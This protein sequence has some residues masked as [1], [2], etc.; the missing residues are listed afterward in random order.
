MIRYRIQPIS[1]ELHRFRVRLL[2]DD[3]DGALRITLPAWIP[4]SYMI[5]DFARNILDLEAYCNALPVTLEK[6]D[7]QTW[8]VGPCR[9]M[10]SL[11]YDV[12]AWD[13]SVRGAHLDT[14][15]AYFNGTS[16]FLRVIDRDREACEVEILPPEGE[17]FEHWR[18]ATTLVRKGAGPFGFGLYQAEDYWE[19]IDNPVE[20][21]DFTLGTFRVSGIEHHLAITG[22][23]RGD[24][25]RIC[26]D[27]E[28][29]CSTHVEMFGE[30]P[31]LEQYLFQLTVVG[32]GYGGLEHRRCTSLLA[33]RDDLPA[34]GRK[35]V[36]DGYRRLLGLCSHE[37]FHLWNVKRITPEV[38]Q[39]ADLASEVHTPLLWAFEG[40]TSYYDDLC[41]VRSGCIGIDGYLELLAQSIT[42]VQRIP[43][44]FRQSIAESSFDAWTKLYKQDENAPNAIVSYYAKGALVALALD[45]TIRVNTEGERS[46]DDVMRL[47][48]QRHGRTGKGVRNGDIEAIVSEVSGEEMGAFFDSYVEGTEDPP[49]QRLLRAVGIGMALRPARGRS[50]QGGVRRDAEPAADGPPPLYLGLR[51]EKNECGIRLASVLEGG[52]A[53]RAGLSAGDLVVAVDGIRC[54]LDGIDEQLARLSPGEPIAVHAFRRDELMRFEVI[55][56]AP[57]ADTCE[58][59]VLEEIDAETRRARGAWLQNGA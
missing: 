14:T 1:P 41:L 26:A 15:H 54:S 50:D 21:G 31:E 13:L 49:L 57:P 8:R 47:L 19:L 16:V 3:V 2:L 17:A 38:M 59:W 46:L 9:G 20:M 11:Q 22:R 40:I 36:S 7:K 12:Y 32:D 34:A 39:Q 24:L 37:Y 51:L 52:P 27:L 56:E 28:K 6:L 4:G 25:G 18:V 5:R 33:R 44:R 35:E 55:P 23:F 53:A 29:I 30:L 45:L 42:R 43:G 10:L 48:W 58:L